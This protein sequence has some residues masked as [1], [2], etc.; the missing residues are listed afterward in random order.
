[1]KNFS[2]VHKKTFNKKPSQKREGFYILVS[3]I[4]HQTTLLLPY[5]ELLPL[6]MRLRQALP[7]FR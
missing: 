5:Q 1:M 6:Y 2:W 4:Q 3:N 7:L